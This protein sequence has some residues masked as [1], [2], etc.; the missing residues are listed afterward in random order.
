[1]H[2]LWLYLLSSDERLVSQL[3]SLSPQV[4]SGVTASSVSTRLI[5][6]WTASWSG[7]NPFAGSAIDPFYLWLSGIVKPGQVA[8]EQAFMSSGAYDILIASDQQPVSVLYEVAFACWAAPRCCA[9]CIVC[10]ALVSSQTCTTVLA[11]WDAP[12]AWTHSSVTNCHHGPAVVKS[13]PS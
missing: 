2:T 13:C 3:G 1:V 8:T 7:D 4:S 10:S 5:E 11:S 9:W 6:T 12:A